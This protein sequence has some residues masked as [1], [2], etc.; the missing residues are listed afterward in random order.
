MF[1]EAERRTAFFT[2]HRHISEAEEASLKPVMDQTLRQ[3]YQE[4]YRCFLCGCALGF[5]LLAAEQTLLLREAFPDVKLF[6]AIPCATQTKGWP[7]RYRMQYQMIREKADSEAV[8]SPFY[9]Q[10][11]MMTRNR[12]MA[13]RSSLCIAYLKEM[14]GGTASTVR[15]AA[16]HRKIKVINLACPNQDTLTG[17]RESKWNYMCISLSAER[18]AGTAPLRLSRVGK[19]SMK[20]M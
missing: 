3:A 5:D 12:F 10:G 13:D 8:L 14:Q 2:G 20:N 6:L 18:N 15:Y 7:E 1:S 16:L 19:M 4:G 9:Y 11:C 17:L